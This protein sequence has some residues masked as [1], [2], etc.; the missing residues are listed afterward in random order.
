MLSVWLAA[1]S[2][3][4]QD[5]DILIQN[6]R[7]ADGTGNPSFLGDVGIKGGRIAG[8]GKLSGK[9]AARTIDAKGLVVAPGFIDMHNH[10]DEAILA[11]GNAESMIRMGVTSMILGEGS[12]S[13]PT[14]EYPRFRDYWAA[15]LKRG[16]STN[17]GSYVGSGLIYQNARG[18]KPGPATAAEVQKMRD[19][20]Q[21][22]M[23][24]GALG[25]STSLH[26]TPGFWISTDELVE[27]AT[28]SAR[29]GGI[30]ATHTRS[31][32]EE[33]F[34]SIS[35]AIQIAKRSGT[36]VDLLH[37]KIA[38]HKLWGQMPE[39]LG[40]IQNARKSGVDVEAHIYPYTAG[41]NAGLRNIIPPWAHE[42]G[43]AKM[44]E[45]LKDPSLRPRLEKDITQGIP[46][47][48]NHYTAVGSDWSKIQIVSTANPAYRNYVGK[49]VSELIADKGKPWLD[50]LFETLIDNNGAVPA[51][52]YH[53][54]EPDMRAA[55]KAPFVSFGS[56]GSAL[57][58]DP[59]GGRGLPH[60][61]SFGTFAR[62]MGH[63]VRDEKVITLEDAVRKA[64]S[65]N[66]AKVRLFDRGLL[67]P[68]M[69]ADVTVFNPDTIADKATYDNP[70]QY[71]VGVEYVLVNGKVVIDKGNHTG[72]RPG[73]ILY[74][75]GTRQ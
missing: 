41:Q 55:M 72:A 45:R 34:E 32:G 63:Y 38:H 56:D 70:Y 1:A 3:S 31:E 66:A 4:A 11:D 43:T 36:T 54:T 73:A 62:V 18:P 30:Y 61:R 2:L 9:T 28:V 19:L 7:I 29:N 52:Y 57:T 15:L 21:Q 26:Q 51:L 71:A 13:A 44:I 10:S 24:D 75:P 27:M 20:I 58:A 16:V 48:Y 74:G 6:G 50:V 14:P 68:G 42:G 65:H 53:H 39:L 69:W 59:A 37:L 35:E 47:W 17:I 40:V 8:L 25:V 64:S 49:R 67:R 12:S 60:P 22:A 33:V 5:F 46:G 23:E